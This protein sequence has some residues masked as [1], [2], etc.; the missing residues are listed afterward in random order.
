MTARVRAGSRS[1]MFLRILVRATVVRRG[2]AMTALLAV[3]IA[4]SVATAVLT[5]YVDIEAK[6]RKEFRSYGANVVVVAKDNGTL[7]ADALARV[8]SVL[9][10]HG[11]AVPFAY[12]VA[13][14]A[15]GSPV[16]ASGTDMV[17]V[18]KLNSW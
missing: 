4:A 1:Q 8:D 15:D 12:A 13:R 11:I 3:V 2:R 14:A 7:P 5:L 18:Q 16:V 17:R 6:L 10:G 9:N